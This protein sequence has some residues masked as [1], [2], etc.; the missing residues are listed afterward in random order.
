M[1]RVLGRVGSLGSWGVWGLWVF[2]VSMGCTGQRLGR[3]SRERGV[4]WVGARGPGLTWAAV[5]AVGAGG[6]EAGG[7]EPAAPPLPLL[8][9]LGP[10]QCQQRAPQRRLQHQRPPARQRCGG[11]LGRSAPPHRTPPHHPKPTRDPLPCVFHAGVRLGAAGAQWGGSAGRWCPLPCVPTWMSPGLAQDKG[12]I[13][14]PPGP[15]K[16]IPSPPTPPLS[17]PKPPPRALTL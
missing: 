14:V 6:E 1:G 16:R 7:A 2:G 15:K 13:V 10:L 17:I 9:R 3:V 5:G 8:L 11:A 12:P 4:I